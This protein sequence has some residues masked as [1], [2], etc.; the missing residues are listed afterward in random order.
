[1]IEKHVEQQ[2]VKGHSEKMTIFYS[3]YSYHFLKYF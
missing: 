3:D 2:N 1:M